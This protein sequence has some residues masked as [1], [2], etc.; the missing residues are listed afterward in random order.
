MKLTF[1]DWEKSFDPNRVISNP[2]AV[3]KKTKKFTSD[4]IFSEKIFGKLDNEGIQYSCSCGKYVGKF[5]HGRK[6]DACNTKVRFIEP[7]LK[8]TGWIDLGDYK[9]IN[10]VFYTFLVKI[11]GKNNLEE[12]INFDK[13]LTKNGLIKEEETQKKNIY[14][15]IGMVSFME[16]F[17]EIFDY[18]YQTSKSKEKEKIKELIEEY[19]NL[20]FVNK[21]PVYSTILR[22]ALMMRENLIFDEVNNDYN[23]LI[24]D[25][26]TLKEEIKVEKKELITLPLLAKMQTT[27]NRIFDKGIENLKGKSGFIRNN[28]LGSRINFSARNVITP[29]PAGYPI[30]GILLPY[31]T[32]LEL[33]RFH[34]LNIISSVKG[35]NKQAAEKI[36]YD[37]TTH[38][39]EEVYSI[40]LD[41]LNKTEGGL[42]ILLNRNPT[43]S[44][45]SI[46][47][48]NV[49]GI[50]K[51][52]TDLTA[53]ISNNILQL[54]AGDYDGDV[55][56]I[57]PIFDRQMAKAFEVYSPKRMIVN[58]NNGAFNNA[59][60]IARDQILGIFSVNN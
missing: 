52:Y 53:S 16:N 2:E 46:L 41:L 20:I 33:Y 45:G 12:T 4:G 57:I 60:N 19:K 1:S 51:D 26:N 36:W 25:S 48:L 6:C 7:I 27:L 42:K 44:Y 54:L 30:D 59:L 43:I 5:Y 49:S 32:F 38:F 22:P 31:L 58:N 18:F 21:I 34:I 28:I 29:L 10:P 39:D 17:D 8:R 55:L 56:N 40:M 15:N 11:I 47:C 9:L 13:K 35:I 50:K 37:A 3:N 14:A 24:L 23:S